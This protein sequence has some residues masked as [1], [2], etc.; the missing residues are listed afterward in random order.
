MNRLDSNSKF[1]SR[2]VIILV[3]CGLAALAS[4]RI[5]LPQ[6]YQYICLLFLFLFLFFYR[7]DRKI[8]NTF[9]VM[10]LF[11][12]VDNG[13]IPY[14]ETASLVRYICYFVL[15][16]SILIHVKFIKKRVFIVFFLAILYLFSSIFNGSEIDVNI[17]VRDI[18]LFSVFS[19]VFMIHSKSLHLFKI[20]TN[21][22]VLMLITFVAFEIPNIIMYDPAN[23][24]L[25]Y[26][27]TKSLVVLIFFASMAS[28]WFKASSAFLLVILILIFYVTRMIIL[29][30][31][32]VLVASIA[33]R[34]FNFKK[35]IKA[36]LY[37][38]A[39]IIFITVLSQY[40]DLNKIKFFGTF[41]LA[42]DESSLLE[43]IKLLDPVRYYEALAFIDTGFNLFIG[44]GFGS[45][46]YDQYGY[47]SFVSENDTAFSLKELK[48][49][50]FFNFHDIWTDVGFRFG[51]LFVFLLYSEPLRK[52][53]HGAA[54]VR[55]LSMTLI[56]LITC[57]FYSMTG[58]ILIA[59]IYLAFLATVHA[60]NS[61]NA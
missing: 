24:Y 2:D 53:N 41:Y 9:A 39:F 44:N 11:S 28:G 60:S 54:E 14:N 17:L 25:S 38:S 42:L 4:M 33:I 15:I 47:F 34:V 35:F 52:I 6:I 20:D 46:V 27:T 7:K 51:L 29:S 8:A 49:G 5:L 55:S 31:I 58:I 23:D 59:L 1:V 61:S 45:G 12:C 37:S 18:F 26:N 19:I 21:F 48:S 32:L 16:F 36:I 50:N 43:I 13:G 56:V 57:A 22:L 3:G 30:F 10:T 40:V